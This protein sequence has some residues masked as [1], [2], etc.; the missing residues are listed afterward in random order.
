VVK[1]NLVLP[2]ALSEAARDV[3]AERARQKFHE[4]FSTRHD[5]THDDGGLALA[6]AAYAWFAAQSEDR[7]ELAV[8]PALWPWDLEGW[9]PTTP[10]RDLVKAGALILAEIER[11]DR[12]AAP[13]N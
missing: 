3:L 9:K 13:A 8:R 5:D 10:R 1:S 2:P 7:R 6:A 11:L 12:A 4:H